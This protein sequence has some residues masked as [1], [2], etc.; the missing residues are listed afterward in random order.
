MGYF[1]CPWP[2]WT[3]LYGEFTLAA[4]AVDTMRRSS[5][6]TDMVVVMTMMMRLIEVRDA[7]RSDRTMALN[8]NTRWRAL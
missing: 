5:V 1:W 7:L 3:Y 8:V 2:A 6:D 4:F